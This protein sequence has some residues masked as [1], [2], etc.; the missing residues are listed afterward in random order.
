MYSVVLLVAATSGGDMAG[1]GGH[2]SSSGCTGSSYTTG[3]YGSSCHGGGFLGTKSGGGLFSKHKSS[4][5][6]STY[7]GGCTGA[8]PA[9]RSSRPPRSWLPPPAAPATPTA[10]AATARAATAAGSWAC[11]TAAV[12]GCSASTRAAATAVA[13][14]GKVPGEDCNLANG[15]HSAPVSVLRA[16]RVYNPSGVA[17][18]GF[19]GVE[20]CKWVCRSCDRV[21]RTWFS[22]CTTDRSTPNSS[23][24]W[25]LKRWCATAAGSPCA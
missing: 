6:G 10:R 11:G 16:W 23:T 20:G 25:P 18:V 8:G 12:V 3:C 4:C 21:S 15:G 17:S 22:G 7:A 9:P 5:H 1:F 13:T 2:K 14:A 19:F 24:W